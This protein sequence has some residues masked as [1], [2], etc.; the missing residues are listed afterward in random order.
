M[1]VPPLRDRLPPHAAVVLK[2]VGWLGLAFVLFALVLLI[3]GKDPLQAY[4]NIISSTLGSTYG[5]SEVVVK[6]IPLVMLALAVAVPA[7]IGLINVGGEGQL[8]IGGLFATWAVL[9]F[10]ALPAWVLVPLMVVLGFV[11]GGMWAAIAAVLRAKGWLLEV[12]STLLLNYIAIL[13]VEVLVF[14]PWRDPTSANYPQSRLF[15][16]AAWLPTFGGTRIHLGVV[17]ALVA[18]V[19]FHVIMGRT[20]WGLEMRAIGGNPEAARRNGIPIFWYIIVVLTIGGGLAG[21][22]GMAEVA[23]IQH[24][25]NPG[26]STGYGYLGFLVSWLAGHRPWAIVLMSFLLAILVSGGDI[27]Q[28]TQS[29]PYSV[30]NILMAL[31]LLVVL[32]GRARK[33]TP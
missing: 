8:Y 18:L 4:A 30:V 33:V 5:L 1:P 22:A 25:L 12:F 14:G 16:A 3:Y 31:I 27:L 21:I 20:R 24:R 13:L 6:M 2:W 23:G 9:T 28:I 17:F 32:A 11:G 19:L 29:L 10:P 7:R 26:L 15:P